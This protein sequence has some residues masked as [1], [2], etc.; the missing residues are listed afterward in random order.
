MYVMYY[1]WLRSDA[2]ISKH[3]GENVFWKLDLYLQ[4][5]SKVVY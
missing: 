4:M 3:I 5:F 2:R 1:N